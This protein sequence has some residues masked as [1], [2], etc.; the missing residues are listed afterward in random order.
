MEDVIQNTIWAEKYRPTNMSSFVGSDTI[1][2]TIKEYINKKDIPNLLFWGSPG[3]GKTSLS[4]VL[5]K[6]IPCDYIYMNASDENSVEDIR[7]KVKNFASTAGFNQLKIIVLDEA[8][9]LSTEAMAILRRICEDYSLYTRFILTCNYIEKIIPAIQSRCQSF[10]ILPP[11]K[12]E[13]GQHIVK[14]LNNEK[15]KFDIKN[16][17]FIINAYYPDIR[18]II[19]FTQQSCVNGKELKIAIENA[20]E[21][22]FKHKIIELLK[23]HSNPIIF[24][25]IRQL[26]ANSDV[27][28]YEMM[29][30]HLYDKVD[31]YAKGK[32][33]LVI[34]EIAE[35]IY[36]SSLVFEKEIT[37]LAC[38]LRIIKILN[39]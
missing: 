25:E 4:K 3:C 16:I 39:K 35:S 36:Q 24:N 26:I 11:S 28:S 37:F 22:D 33:T 7:N 27:S 30:R 23:D 32:E 1:K 6:S 21:T 18:K 9:F 17:A 34:I 38:I 10:E 15:I 2:E 12:K 29:F 31:E 8:D 5:I 14:I 20:V 19:N 13:I